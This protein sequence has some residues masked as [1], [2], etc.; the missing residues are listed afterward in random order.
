MAGGER[1][2]LEPMLREPAVPAP[3][4]VLDTNVVHDWIALRD[5]RVQP[6]VAAIERGDLHTADACL[7]EL[8]RVLNYA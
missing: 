8:R 2:K 6:I 3:L 1:H 4:L 5:P 7:P